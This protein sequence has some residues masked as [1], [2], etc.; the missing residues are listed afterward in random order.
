MPTGILT[1]VEKMLSI[2]A[3]SED[4]ADQSVCSAALVSSILTGVGVLIALP[5]LWKRIIFDLGGVRH[6]G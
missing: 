4:Q 1:S 3:E 5:V 6:T 2:S